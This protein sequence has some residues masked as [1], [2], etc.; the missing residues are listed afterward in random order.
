MTEKFL[1][2]CI[3][4]KHD[5]EADWKKSSL[6]PLQGEI[7]VYDKDETY[8]YERIKVGDGETNV[9]ALPFADEATK[10]K[11][12]EDIRSHNSAEDA[13]SNMGW[14]TSGDE[15]AAAPVPIDADTLGGYDADYFLDKIEESQDVDLTGYATE[16][17]VNSLINLGTNLE[18]ITEFTLTENC[19]KLDILVDKD[20]N[21]FSLDVATLQLLTPTDGSCGEGSS[22]KIAVGFGSPT[23][24]YYLRAYSAVG[25]PYRGYQFSSTLWRQSGFYY[26]ADVRN[27]LGVCEGFAGDMGAAQGSSM[28]LGASYCYADQKITRIHVSSNLPANA[29]VKVY[30]IRTAVYPNVDNFIKSTPQIL[31]AEQKSQARIN[32]DAMGNGISTHN[33]EV[34]YYHSE[35]YTIQVTNVQ[36]VGRI[37]LFCLQIVVNTKID[38]TYGFTLA[39]LPFNT[40]MR[41]WINNGTQ[42]Y[43]DAGT[44]GIRVNNSTIATGSY[45]LSGFYFISE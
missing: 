3:V 22:G 2:S 44:N 15:E 42:F 27:N 10:E 9:N 41:I 19:S 29:V 26:Y 45:K 6:V 1:K 13:H 40:S 11:I 36:R 34:E 35:N 23:N 31:T 4:H 7:V 8:D 33:S 38:S 18:L 20:G 32:I 14:L 39:A 37:C 43:M 17:Y 25:F 28:K 24:Q 16:E 21:S 30:G 12:E 5:T